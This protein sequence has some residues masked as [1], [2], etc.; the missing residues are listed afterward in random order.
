[1][2]KWVVLHS[3]DGLID[4]DESEWTVI[5]CSKKYRK[6]SEDYIEYNHMYVVK[7]LANLSHYLLGM[8]TKML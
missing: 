2:D 8:H 3:Y 4:R 5:A 6:K 1:M 7:K